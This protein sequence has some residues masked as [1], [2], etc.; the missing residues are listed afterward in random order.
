M[1]TLH[2]VHRSPFERDALET[3]LRV[4]APGG[5]VLLIEDAVYAALVGTEWEPRLRDAMERLE[6][7]VLEPDLRARGLDPAAL[8]AGVGCV[9][10][11]GFVD[12]AAACDRVTAWL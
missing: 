10:Y 2:T 11:G 9:G 3:C 12:L 4:A 1:P 6:V 8:I 5:R 7:H